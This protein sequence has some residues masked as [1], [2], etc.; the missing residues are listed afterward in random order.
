MILLTFSLLKCA[1]AQTSRCIKG[2]C[3]W[4]RA[5]LHTNFRAG[6]HT[7]HLTLHWWIYKSAQSGAASVSLEDRAM[8]T[9]RT[10]PVFGDR[11]EFAAQ[12]DDRLISR[13]RFLGAILLEL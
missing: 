9:V 5:V 7:F 12:E 13:F 4:K 6:L 8:G 11:E 2:G 3:L 1:H 10:E